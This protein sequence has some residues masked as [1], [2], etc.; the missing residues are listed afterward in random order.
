LTGILEEVDPERRGLID[1]KAICAHLESELSVICSQGTTNW[2]T[3]PKIGPWIR[4]DCSTLAA[5][6]PSAL[7]ISSAV[8]E[9]SMGAC[10]SPASA[11]EATQAA[12][13][14]K[15]KRPMRG[16]AMCGYIRL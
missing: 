8:G 7:L 2:P 4:V 9:E 12:K 1:R 11:R 16:I 10:L 15:L 5:R 3:S 13:I 14:A 6:P